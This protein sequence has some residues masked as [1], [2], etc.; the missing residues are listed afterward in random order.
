MIKTEGL[1]RKLREIKNGAQDA[2]S[3]ALAR[4][5]EYRSM[6]Y[7]EPTEVNLF[8]KESV[9]GEALVKDVMRTVEGAIPSLVQP[10]IGK[11]IVDLKGSDGSGETDEIIREIEYSI[12]HT[13]NRKHNPLESAEVLARSMQVDGTTVG[14]VGWDSDGFPT[15]KNVP[16]ESIILD[17][18]AYTM[19][20]SRFAIEVR[21]VTISEILANPLWFGK[22]TLEELVIAS[23]TGEGE[24]DPDM[25]D[26]AGQDDAFDMGQRANDIVEIFEFHGLIDIDGSGVSKPIVGIWSDDMDLNAFDSPYATSGFWNPFE[27]GVY[28]RRP[29]TLYGSSVAHLIG[30]HQETRQKLLRGVLKSLDNSTSGQVFVKKGAL[31]AINFKRYVKGHRVVEVNGGNNDSLGDK[32]FT[33]QYDQLPSDILALMDKYETEEEN[34]TGI[35]K[36]SVG[37]DSR[38][39]NQTATGVSIISSMSQRRLVF[40]TQHIS[41]MLARVFKKWVLL[42]GSHKFGMDLSDIDVY[43]RA[44]T[45]GIQAKKGQ[46]ITAMLSAISPYVGSGMIDG[47]IITTLVADLAE[48]F[49]LDTTAKKI[50]DYALEV[51]NQKNDPEAQQAMQHENQVTQ[52]IALQKEIAIIRKDES[53]ADRNRAVAENQKIDAARKMYQPINQEKS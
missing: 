29:W 23:H 19:D 38:A 26:R 40:I 10:F 45:A 36:Y 14:K 39:L 6:Y 44:G 27:L 7:N 9:H 48:T 41:S 33:G 20:D 35:T 1:F 25:Y 24:F 17:P 51:E 2:H 28:I 31:D 47:H 30:E 4:I 15:F 16:I 21:K 34:L 13:W 46:D 32:F 50:R 22:H 49:E 37:S 43:V 53:I 5:S 18:A 3:E 12:N 11:D 8:R 42:I 52:E